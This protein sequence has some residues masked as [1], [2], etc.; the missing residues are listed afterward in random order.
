MMTYWRKAVASSFSYIFHFLLR[1]LT[2]SYFIKVMY[3]GKME[4]V[5]F[6]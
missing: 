5:S 3:I 2:K 1:N 4:H 6:I